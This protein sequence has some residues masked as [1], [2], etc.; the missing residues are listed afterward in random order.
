MYEHHFSNFGQRTM[1]ILAIFRSPNLRRLDMIFE[2][3]W[4][5]CFK[6]KSFEN[7][8]GWT[9]R[10]TDDGQRVSTV[11]QSEHSSGELKTEGHKKIGVESYNLDFL[12]H[13]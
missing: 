3:N 9:D 10:R 5:S 7:V 1:T 6:E 13:Q 4:L 8:N 2:Q 12:I 11:A